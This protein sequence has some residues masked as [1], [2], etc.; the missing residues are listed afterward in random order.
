MTIHILTSRRSTLPVL[1]SAAS[2]F[3]ASRWS[4]LRIRR[5][6]ST[7]HYAEI[8]RYADQHADLLREQFR[9][10]KPHVTITGSVLSIV[11]DLMGMEVPR[12]QGEC[13]AYF[14]DKVLGV[15]L[16]FYH[17]QQRMY[18]KETTFSLL[19]REL[20]YHGFA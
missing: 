15:C 19:K 20:R 12:G 6:V 7:S 16:D 10:Y 1:N 3:V 4:T 17:P 13:F 18:S 11:S 9:V 8:K 14:K 2:T 5:A